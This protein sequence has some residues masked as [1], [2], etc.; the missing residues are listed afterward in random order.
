MKIC[1]VGAG[2][3]GL[4]LSAALAS[5]GHDMI[6]TDKDVKKIEQLK[7]GD[8]PFY[9]PGLSDAVHHCD[10]LSFSSEVKLSMEE[11]PVIFIA[12]GTPPRSDGS[13]DTKALQSVI[14]D[15]SQTIRSY[16]TIITKST[17]PPGTNEN[18]AKQLIA[19]GVSA[20]SFNIVSNPEFL[21][22]GSALHDMLYPDKTVI[23]IEKGD[24]V[25]AAIVKSIYKHIDTP[26][27]ITSLAGAE[28][29]K[30]ANNFFLA[31]KI[32]FINEMAR[33]CE[34]Y[35]S[36]ITD[37]SRAIGLDPRIGEHFLQA[38]IGYGGSC[39]PKDLQA[40]QFAAIEKN[41]ET[42]L[43]QAVQHINDTQIGLYVKKIKS[44]FDTLHGKKAAILG[45][46]FKP[47]TDDIR[48]SQAVR[49]MER[50]T[51]LGCDVHAYDPE[52]VLPEHLRQRVTQHSQAFDAIEESDFL[53]LATEWPE[54]LAIDWKKAAG[55]MKGR[56]VID[57]RNV[58][59][60]E[61]LEACGLICTGVGRP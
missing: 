43:L 59:K 51:D 30:Y 47:H 54:F 33:I 14:S 38:G 26:Y 46:S 15:L 31:A 5:I 17:V 2:Y 36:D 4:T 3:V 9:E 37:I 21:R 56:V 28:L 24:H 40:L 22:E 55:T 29:I 18:I 10:N 6:C 60:K 8:I 41:T 52:A 13:A 23:G 49:L 12:V 35:Q 57:G 53:F 11:C 58:L 45:I 25:S 39:F 32:S 44:F 27:I 7:N 48:N 50:L 34:A 42:Y 61:S 16:K 20:N 19:S 1:V